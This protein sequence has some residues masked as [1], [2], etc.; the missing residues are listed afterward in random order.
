M[1]STAARRPSWCGRRSTTGRPCSPPS[2]GPVSAAA[3]S[4][5]AEGHPAAAPCKRA[6]KV[7]RPVRPIRGGR[8]EFLA[9]PSF[10][11]QGGEDAK[12]PLAVAGRRGVRR[13]RG[14]LPVVRVRVLT[15][16][17]ADQVRALTVGKAGR[18]LIP[19]V[20]RART[21]GPGTDSNGGDGPSG[22]GRANGEV[23][24]VR[25]GGGGGPRVRGRVPH[26]VGRLSG[27][28]VF[29]RRAARRGGRGRP[30]RLPASGRLR[31]GQ[32]FADGGGRRV[33]GAARG[34]PFRT[35]RLC[36]GPVF[37]PLRSGFPAGGPVVR[38]SANST[39]AGRL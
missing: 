37:G 2:A 24:A 3:F 5:S 20:R 16:E 1:I 28:S 33:R 26:D 34:R 29:V 22:K 8:G 21:A 39:R 17:T 14:R 7:R 32:V 35:R 10:T 13:H 4:T 27:R 23:Q 31:L 11:T 36:V 30:D 18:R 25:V 9:G 15:Q 6:H 19:S 38:P 12:G